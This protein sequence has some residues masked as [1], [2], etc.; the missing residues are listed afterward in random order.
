LSSATTSVNRQ[1]NLKF[2]C[3]KPTI[4]FPVFIYFCLCLHESN[5]F[6][7][8]IKIKNTPFYWRIHRWRSTHL[9]FPFVE[10]SCRPTYDGCIVVYTRTPYPTWHIEFTT[11]GAPVNAW[12]YFPGLKGR[13]NITLLSFFY[14]L[15]IKTKYG[16]QTHTNVYIPINESSFNSEFTL[17]EYDFV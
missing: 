16:E 14:Y 17:A 6:K 1:W 7:F 5:P 3:L 10:S 9:F 2:S 15:A 4:K 13:N 11:Y 12:P 8:S